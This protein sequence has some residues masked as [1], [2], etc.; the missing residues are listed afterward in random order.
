MLHWYYK[1]MSK[2]TLNRLD[3]CVSHLY[4][5]SRTQAVKA[6]KSGLVIVDDEIVYDPT[7]KVESSCTI[8]YDEYEINVKEGFKPRVFMLNKPEGFVCADKDNHNRVVVDLFF[9][10][11]HKGNLHCAGRLDLDTTGLLIVTD[12][13]ALIHDITSPKKEIPKVY[14]AVTDNDL[15]EKFITLFARG[16]HH[17]EEKKRYKSAK[18]EILDTR[19]ARVTVSEGRYHEVKR[20][21]E[22]VGLNVIQL[23]RI[24]IGSLALDENLE[25]GEYRLLDD[26]EIKLMFT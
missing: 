2:S 7:T 4:G 13:G 15:E 9:N 22:C 11:N 21:F 16:L 19:L 25:E 18:L 12:D 17:K 10:E 23:Q 5:L 20:L 6:I 24:Q 26:N 8:S 1:K 14:L 3:K